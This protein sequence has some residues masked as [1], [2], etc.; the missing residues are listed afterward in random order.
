MA[1]AINQL[2]ADAKLRTQFAEAGRQYVRQKFA[3]AHTYESLGQ[4]YKQVLTEA[5]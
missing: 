1:A 4:L 3:P 5:A 2:A